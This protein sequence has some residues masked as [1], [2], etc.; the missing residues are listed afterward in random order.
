MDRIP[1]HSC[2]LAAAIQNR[3]LLLLFE[4][5]PVFLKRGIIQVQPDGIGDCSL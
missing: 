2:H 1:L 5:K 3:Q 4:G